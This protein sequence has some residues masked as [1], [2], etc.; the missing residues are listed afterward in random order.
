[1]KILQVSNSFKPAWE[2]GGTTRV[3]YDISH[4]LANLGHEITVYTTDRGQERVKIQKNSS[5]VV[6]N[7]VVYY[8]RNISNYLAMKLNIVTPY[9]LFFA[10][11]KQIKKF[12]VI[13]IHEHRTFLAVVVAYFARRY[14]VPYMVQAHGS[15][16][17]FYQKTLIK[18]I[19]DKLWGNNILNGASK[20]IALTK[21]E[22]QQYE[23]M[24]IDETRIEI[25]PNGINLFEYKKLPIKG[26]FRKKYD[27]KDDEKI[28]LYLGRLNRIKGIDV[29]LEAFSDLLI[30]TKNVKLVIAGPDDGLLKLLLE[31]SIKLKLD[32]K[33]IFTGPIYD[34]NK[35][36]AYIDANVYVLPSV[37]E[38]FPNTVIESCACGTP[39][40]IT[41]RCGISNLIK[42][43]VGCIV[44]LDK[45]SLRQALK[46]MLE[47]EQFHNKM[48]NNC[49]NFVNS[50]FNLKNTMHKLES[51]YSL[52]DEFD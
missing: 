50:E 12:D 29:L 44:T 4:Q 7:F 14:N 51:I 16:M 10:A 5:V 48:A 2:T 17:P 39:V 35:I 11:R 30:D 26:K 25:I 19:F 31:L 27:I 41:D 20:V 36:E 24:G 3:V 22:S 32:D 23:K 49:K 1:M 13:H 38:T 43:N 47:N 9:Y 40:I 21:I 34:L 52:S 37:Y 6:D 33:I 45:E 8:F 15:V 46:C 28:I 18:K 42:N